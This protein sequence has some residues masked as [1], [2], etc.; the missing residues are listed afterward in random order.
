MP[1][2]IS[3]D[4]Q[5]ELV[6]GNPLEKRKYERKIEVNLNTNQLIDFSNHEEVI[7]LLN[8]FMIEFLY[9]L[10]TNSINFEGFECL[11]VISQLQK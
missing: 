1:K 7:E 2:R 5:I 11:E 8:Q 9:R 10:I 6:Q 3:R 4:L